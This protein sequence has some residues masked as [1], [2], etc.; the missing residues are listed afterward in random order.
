MMP[1]GAALLLA[2]CAAAA[3]LLVAGVAAALPPLRTTGCDVNLY[4]PHVVVVE[5]TVVATHPPSYRC[6]HGVLTG[7][8]VD[9]AMKLLDPRS[10]EAASGSEVLE[11]PTA[12][13]G[14]ILIIDSPNCAQIE[15]LVMVGGSARVEY[16][17]PF[18]IDAE[19]DGVA[20]HARYS[21]HTW[22]AC[23]LAPGLH[24]VRL[25]TARGP[26]TCS[27]A[28]DAAANA[29]LKI[30][31]V[32]L[33]VELRVDRVHRGAVRVGQTVT[34]G[35]ANYTG[36]DYVPLGPQEIVAWRTDDDQPRA[37]L[38]S[39]PPSQ[40]SQPGCTRCDAGGSPS[41]ILLGL[42]VALLVLRRHRR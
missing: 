31:L 14:C 19:V 9:E 33:T 21:N 16:E 38:C 11:R 18:Y 36:P 4:D 32:T 26:L 34:V 29:V 17:E 24:A 3:P 23:S 22:R 37:T 13:D 10:P 12:S 6:G 39:A 1:R 28:V 5:A 2:M 27:V 40:P 25:C 42:V 8:N 41:W 30:E 7:Y 20:R 35:L 15:R